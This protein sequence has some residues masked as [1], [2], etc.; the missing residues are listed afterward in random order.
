LIFKR[1]FMKNYLF[2]IIPV[3]MA[4]CIST[5]AT[6]VGL[7]L[8]NQD[9]VAIARGNAFVAT[10]D[11]PS[12]IYH[13][14]A[15]IT[16]LKGKQ[17]SIGA[18]FISAD[19]SYESPSGAKGQTDTSIQAVPQ[20]HYVYSP[21]NS[22]FSFG[23]G[24]YVPFGL[25]IDYGQSSPF[26][27]LAKEGVLS[28]ISVNPVVAYEITDS[29]SI[30]AGFT[31]NYST[32][33]LTQELGLVPDDEFSYEGDAVTL[34]YNLGLRWDINQQFS[35]GASYRSKTDIDYEGR[36]RATSNAVLQNYVDTSLSITSPQHLDVGLAYR[37]NQEW[38][39]ETNVDWTDWSVLD[40][41]AFEGTLLGDI[42]FLFNYSASLMYEFGVTKHLGNGLDISAGYIFSENSAP[43]QNFTPYNPDSDLHLGSFGVS[44]QTDSGIWSVGYHFGYNGGRDVVNNQAGSLLGEVADGHYETLNH[45]I[46]ISFQKSF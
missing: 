29:L 26:P 1:E 5:Q 22:A 8:P 10:A 27:T 19:V 41:T 15:G 25:G 36:S 46:N 23:L 33:E 35:F 28:Y 42:P 17:L 6:A 37:P 4:I 9:P 24:L 30:A 2:K 44:K 14:P 7:R 32:V 18:Y 34:G 13:N 20:I 43:D 31:F 45:A 39:F 11:N 21:E 3:S 38:L 12:A 40:A 16:Q